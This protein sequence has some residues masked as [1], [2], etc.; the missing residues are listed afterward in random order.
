VNTRTFVIVP[1]LTTILAACGQYSETPESRPV[2][3]PIGSPIAE[4][5]QQSIEINLPGID[6]SVFDELQTLTI[7]IVCQIEKSGGYYR[8]QSDVKKQG[9]VNY[10]AAT[11]VLPEPSQ[12]PSQVA[13]SYGGGDTKSS[14]P[15]DAG[16]GADNQAGSV[17]WKPF[18]RIAQSEDG[19]LVDTNKAVDDLPN[20][21]YRIAGG[22]TA[23][24]E[25]YIDSTSKIHFDVTANYKEYNILYDKSNVYAGIKYVKDV[26]KTRSMILS[27]K[28]GTWNYQGTDQVFKIMTSAASTTDFGFSQDKPF[29]ANPAKW[30]DA[31]VGFRDEKTG[32]ITSSPFSSV[33]SAP[34]SSPPDMVGPASNNAAKITTRLKSKFEITPF[35]GLNLVGPVNSTIS[36]AMQVKNIGPAGSILSYDSVP[37]GKKQVKGTLQSGKTALLNYSFTCPATPGTYKKQFT[38]FY[39]EN[40]TLRSAGDQAVKS[41]EEQAAGSPKVYSAVPGQILYSSYPVNLS[42][43]CFA[44]QKFQINPGNIYVPVRK[45]STIK[46]TLNVIALDPGQPIIGG[47]EIA[48]GPNPGNPAAASITAQSIV[49]NPIVTPSALIAQTAANSL[50]VTA[51]CGDVA[52]NKT[53]TYTITDPTGNTE[54]TDYTV[55]LHCLGPKMTP[56]T[57]NPLTLTAPVGGTAS[58]SFSFGNEAEAASSGERAP[59]SYSVSGSTGLSVS[60]ASG[61][62]EG[63]GTATIAVSYPCTVAGSFP[64]T[65]TVKSD[66]AA[67]AS[68]EV[69]VVVNCDSGINIS[70]S[71]TVYQIAS[72]GQSQLYYS[73]GNDTANQ[74]VTW[75]TNYGTLKTTDGKTYLSTPLTTP[76]EFKDITVTATSVS[77]PGLPDHHLS[78]GHRVSDCIWR[79]VRALLQHRQ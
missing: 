10:F 3:N 45:T 25:I 41:K 75:K 76:G 69:Q 48:A 29:V 23:T 34:C 78:F 37:L 42:F 16:F 51:T 24:M 44:K 67:K 13:Y 53:F 47:Y 54:P 9:K 31:V 74:G 73:I 19:T 70:V 11:V 77:D 21:T 32:K 22:Q 61:T 6:R 30:N 68:S 39:S 65:A 18:A 62:V 7:P 12:T 46:A 17:L 58:G 36:N 63:G 5:I 55:T 1:I 40:D 2:I 71:A 43:G 72:G 20:V 27:A 59:L 79:S 60:P 56:P 33:S 38:V 50:D 26:S 8:L 15:L 4:S 28:K 66:D 49:V 35:N 14:N 64:L 57:P 52:E